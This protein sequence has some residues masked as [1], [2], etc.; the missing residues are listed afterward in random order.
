M[1]DLG[2][3]SAGAAKFA[4]DL[5]IGLPLA[6]FASGRQNFDKEI[7]L[8]IRQ[9][10]GHGLL[11]YRLGR[12]RNDEDQVIIEPQVADYWPGTPQLSEADVLVLSQFAYLRRRGNEMVL[13][14]PRARALFKICNPKIAA[15]IAA[16]YTPQQIKMCRRQDGFPGTELLAL[17]VD[18][19]ILFKINATSHSSLRGAEGDDNLVLWDFHDL[20]F[21]TRS[22]EGRHINPLGGL[23]PYA[24]VVPPLPAVR[25]RWPGRRIDLRKFLAAHSEIT[26]PIVKLLHERHS[27]RI[28]DDQNPIT[29][30][31]VSRF[32]DKTARILSRRSTRIESGDGGLLVEYTV[33]PYPSAGASYELEL[34]LTVDKCEGLTRGFYHYDAA[35]HV[36][37]PISART[38]EFEVVLTGAK[39]AMDAPAAPQILITIAAR[40]GRISWKYSSL[41]YELILKDVGVLTQTL[42]LVAAEMGLGGCAV[43][44]AN[45][46]LFAKMTG[47]EFHVEGP[48]GH[49]SLGRGAKS[50]AGGD[51]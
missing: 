25:P 34:Y 5:H 47:I 37:V 4:Q 21:H 23:Y 45:I 26:S 14:S 50:S 41:A 32:L 16:L 20:L 43:G 3:F 33:R 31:E 30:A 17:L 39:F 44:S 7:H 15:A 6:S 18:C 8:L 46:D 22:T 27:T 29:I 10:A 49:F 24:D 12:S 51:H 40:F 11:E 13:E 19:Q 42:Y 28:F 48:V 2:T 35:G 9:L 38:H 1:V 36:L